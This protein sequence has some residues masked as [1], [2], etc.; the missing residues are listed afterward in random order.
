MPS[1]QPYLVTPKLRLPEAAQVDALEA[2]LGAPLPAGYR[3]Y[4]LQW[5]SGVYGNL[6][7][8]QMP[9]DILASRTDEAGFVREW[10]AEFWGEKS[11]LTQTDAVDAW[12]FAYT[13]DGDKIRYCTRRQALFV[14]P[15]HD[16]KV[17]WMPQGFVDPLD[18][19][20]ARQAPRT[21]DSGL[22][23][24][25]RELFTAQASTVDALAGVIGQHYTT[26]QRIDAPWGAVLMLPALHGRAQLTQAPGDHRVGLRLEFDAALEPVALLAELERL[27]WFVRA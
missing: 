27:G 10:Y 2:A 20:H 17:I 11:D 25:V 23:R 26:A 9:E 4:V 22:D 5:G 7:V 19:G 16:D 6:L 1:V 13:L 3:E 14:L 21:F 15:R 8:V 24:T 12:P 18:W